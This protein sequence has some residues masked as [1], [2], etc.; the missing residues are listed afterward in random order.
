MDFALSKKNV[1]FIGLLLFELAV[2]VGWAPAEL[3]FLG[4]RIV[5]AII[6][7][8]LVLPVYRHRESK[9]VVER[10]GALAG[11]H[12]ATAAGH[13]PQAK[14]RDMAI[15]YHEIRNCTSTLKGNAHLLKQGL[16]ADVDLAPV[17]RIERVASCI[18]RIAREVMEL[19]EPT[20]PVAVRQRVRL[21][22]LFRECVEDYFPMRRAAFRFECPECIPAIEGDPG[23]LRQAMVNLIK[24]AFEAGAGTVVFRAAC[25]S[26]TLAVTI[27]DDG[28]GCSPDDLTK[29][30]LPMHSSKRAIGGMGLGLA[31]VKATIEQL[32]GEVWAAPRVDKGVPTRGV[33]IHMTLPLQ[34]IA[35]AKPA[36]GNGRMD[37]P[38]QT[39]S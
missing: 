13:T 39:A 26:E 38:L 28:K 2:L 15:L 24:N 7:L 33:A 4:L 34:Q 20:A 10:S 31:L 8:F 3:W 14:E 27:E 11:A 16:P 1:I 36:G 23:K 17:E 35:W 5:L 30:F 37:R 22:S 9:R 29:I 12:S 6:S 21:D 18:E 32:G 25:R 19:A